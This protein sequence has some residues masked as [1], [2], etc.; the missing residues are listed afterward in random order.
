MSSRE[1]INTPAPVTPELRKQHKRIVPDWGGVGVVV[2]RELI[3]V[4]QEI[5]IPGP[6]DHKHSAGLFRKRKSLQD[7]R[8]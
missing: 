6:Q 2:R 4:Y 7:P 8:P 1:N 3:Q 5:T